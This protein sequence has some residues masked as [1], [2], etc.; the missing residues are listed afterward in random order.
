MGLEPTNNILISEDSTSNPFLSG[1]DPVFFGSCFLDDEL[2]HSEN[3]PESRS[4]LILH[5]RQQKHLPNVHLLGG[6]PMLILGVLSN[7]W[8]KPN[9]LKHICLSQIGF[10]FTQNRDKNQETLAWNQRLKT[11]SNWDSSCSINTETTNPTQ[12]VY[13]ARPSYVAGA[14]PNAQQAFGIDLWTVGAL[15]ARRKA[16]TQTVQQKNMGISRLRKGMHSNEE[17]RTEK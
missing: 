8:L 10:F 6:L 2:R 9:H 16:T 12:Y 15:N 14:V 3:Q 1:Q 5:L 17:R 4:R 13:V 11:N 7:G